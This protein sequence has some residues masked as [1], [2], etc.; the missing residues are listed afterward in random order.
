MDHLP[1]Q[2]PQAVPV[3]RVVAHVEKQVPPPSVP[4][5]Q[6]RSECTRVVPPPSVALAPP[7]RLS[8]VLLAASVGGTGGRHPGESGGDVVEVEGGGDASLELVELPALLLR[9]A[10]AV[11]VR[12]LPLLL[13]RGYFCCFRCF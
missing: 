4:P 1:A 8:P 2:R 6:K 11:L 7:D 3:G 5:F 9:P 10:G 13:V 12:A